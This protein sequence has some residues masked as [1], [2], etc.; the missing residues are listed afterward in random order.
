M[1]PHGRPAHRSAAPWIA[2]ALIAL[3]A[4][5]AWGAPAGKSPQSLLGPSASGFS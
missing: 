4:A 2:V 3:A 5:P 1:S